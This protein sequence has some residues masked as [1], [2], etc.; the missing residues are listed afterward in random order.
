V[1][2][3]ILSLTLEKE[4]LQLALSLTD[5]YYRIR[6]GGYR[7]T[8]VKRLQLMQTVYRFEQLVQRDAP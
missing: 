1:Q 8:R 3:W 6:F 4:P 2:S 5:T 7:P